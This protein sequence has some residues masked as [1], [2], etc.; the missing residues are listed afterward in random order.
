MCCRKHVAATARES[1]MRIPA[2]AVLTIGMAL[3]S[4]PAAA[5]TYDPGYPVC[6]QTYGRDGN[7]ISCGYYSLAQCNAAASGRAAQ[8]IVNPY[9]ARPQ[10][11]PRYG[12]RRGVY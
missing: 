5:Q 10:A 4:A 9:F 7:S 3:T 11:E 8:C 1:M 2:L 12:R 6:L